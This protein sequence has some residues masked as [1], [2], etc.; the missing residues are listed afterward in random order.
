MISE[1]KII[2]QFNSFKVTYMLNEM[3]ATFHN[4]FTKQRE[5]LASLCFKLNIMRLSIK[6]SFEWS[7]YAGMAKYIQ[8]RLKEHNSGN[9]INI[10]K[11]NKCLSGICPTNSIKHQLSISFHS[12][13]FT[14]EN[15]PLLFKTFTN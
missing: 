1:E 4:E 5:T 11:C 14:L 9:T 7:Y 3:I 8:L 12:R 6:E 13:I 10:D 15:S 2:T